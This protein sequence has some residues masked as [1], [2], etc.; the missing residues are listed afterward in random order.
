M[1]AERQRLFDGIENGR[2]ADADT[3]GV[4]LEQWSTA[5]QRLFATME[6]GLGDP[7]TAA[8]DPLWWR[9]RRA[10]DDLYATWQ[11]HQAPHTFF[12]TPTVVIRKAITAPFTAPRSASPPHR[13]P[14]V[15]LSRLTQIPEDWRPHLAEFGQVVFGGEHWDEEFAT[16]SYSTGELHTATAG[17]R[18]DHADFAYFLRLD[19]H[20]PDP[21]GVT[22]RVF[23][24]AQEAAEDRRAWMEMDKFRAVLKR[25]E[26]SVTA[27]PASLSSVIRKRTG[28]APSAR[29]PDYG[30]CGLPANLLLPKG[31]ADGMKFRLLVMLTSGPPT[32][33][34]PTAR[35]GRSASAAG[36]PATP[37][38]A[39]WATPSTAPCPTARRSP[40]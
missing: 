11:S 32:R 10:V 1:S 31:R 23:L 21:A 12:D 14:D 8:R 16:T 25:G 20:G 29:D 19:N 3:L 7:A 22:V 38:P 6:P 5:G 34:R 13:S 33:S 26:R 28:A 39:P 17:G 27:R 18:L 24:A 35:V 4:A 36:A 2:F 9:W 40:S 30:A 15:I 37:T